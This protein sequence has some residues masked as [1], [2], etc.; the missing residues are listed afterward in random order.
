MTNPL[1]IFHHI[2]SV[3]KHHTEPYN[4]KF[5]LSFTPHITMGTI[6]SNFILILR[7]KKV[8]GTTVD[9]IVE[10]IFNDFN[11]DWIENYS[12]V[13]NFFN[14]SINSISI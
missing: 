12:I 2:E 7:S 5:N 14:I 10:N 1:N 4:I 8:E 13:N 9:K 6:A 3:I 11:K